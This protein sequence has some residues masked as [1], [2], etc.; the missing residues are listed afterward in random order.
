MPTRTCGSVTVTAG[1]HPSRRPAAATG[2]PVRWQV[3]NGSGPRSG[4]T[5]IGWANRSGHELSTQGTG[6][7][8]R[9][10]GW[11]GAR[12]NTAGMSTL[13]L[14]A[15]WTSRL[16]VLGALTVAHCFTRVRR[17]DGWT[18]PSSSA[19][20]RW[21]CLRTASVP[22]RRA[23]RPHCRAE[24]VAAVLVRRDTHT[25]A[26]EE[27]NRPLE[28]RP[29]CIGAAP[30][31]GRALNVPDRRR[32]PGARTV[33][34]NLTVPN[35]PAHATRPETAAT[36]DGGDSRRPHDGDAQCQLGAAT[37]VRCRR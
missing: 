8:R 7:A 28:A 15:R 17:S 21:G 29:P 32:T 12:R 30:E 33:R 20:S 24:A 6:L 36:H 27:P 16:V 31:R 18:R 2:S 25:D 34:C 11:G 1:G 23:S 22:C 3:Q 10:R 5:N 26:S 13:L 9:R 37:A 14:R 19:H 4:S 35:D